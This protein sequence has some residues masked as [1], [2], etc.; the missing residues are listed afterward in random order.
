ML[1]EFIKYLEEQIGQPYMWGGQHTKLTPET[2]EA[3]IHAREDGRGGYKD[4]TSYADAGIAFCKKKFDAG[5]D[6]L[7]AYDCSGLGMYWIENLKHLRDRDASANTMM[8]WCV[9]LDDPEPPEK[10]WW[11]FRINDAGKATHIGY[12]IDDE[13]LIEAKGRKWGVVVTEFDEE[14][15]DCWGIPD[16]FY[17][18]IVNPEPDPPEPPE[19]TDKVVKVIGKS[20]RVRKKDTVLSKTLFIAHN[21]AWYREHGFGKKGD[22]FPLLG[23]APSGWYCIETK[24]G[25]AY[26]TNKEK[27]TKLE[28][29]EA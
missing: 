14:D 6:V 17:N 26:I 22:E 11:V 23:T 5:A 28:D 12:M 25:E 13:T 4:G 2:Y 15:W 21:R 27:Y 29:K 20:V 1:N 16:V 9:N 19:P 10:G 24:D 3:I 7:Y 18:E 8:H